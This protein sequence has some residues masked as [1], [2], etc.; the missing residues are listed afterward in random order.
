[1]VGIL[2]LKEVHNFNIF[3]NPLYIFPIFS[4]L[5]SQF[6]LLHKFYQIENYYFY[7]RKEYFDSFLGNTF[8]VQPKIIDTPMLPHYGSFLFKTIHP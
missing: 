1:M 2:H 5:T 6:S 7:C 4:L 3:F 8:L